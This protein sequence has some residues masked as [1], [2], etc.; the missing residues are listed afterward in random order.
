MTPEVLKLRVAIINMTSR[1][2]DAERDYAYAISRGSA[3]GR[4][5]RRCVRRRDAL[6]RLVDA[7]AK[8]LAES[9][10][11]AAV[12]AARRVCK[13]YTPA[14]PSLFANPSAAYG[15]GF[16]EGT[17]TLGN[18]VLGAIDDAMGGQR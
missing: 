11:V 7:L 4:E 18:A 15:R 12:A 5:R 6:L 16:N 10:E 9:P 3:A 14:P 1:Y 17:K 13:S 2:G 8:L